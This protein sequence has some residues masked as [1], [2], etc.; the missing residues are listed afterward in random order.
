M[1]GLPPGP[2]TSLNMRHADTHHVGMGRFMHAWDVQP[3]TMARSIHAVSRLFLAE[4]FD[5]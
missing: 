1:R 3:H 2:L 5:E 4:D